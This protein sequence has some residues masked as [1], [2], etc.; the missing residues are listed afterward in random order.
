[1]L[2]EGA[3]KDYHYSLN[4]SYQRYTN[5]KNMIYLP[6]PLNANICPSK[7]ITKKSLITKC[8]YFCFYKKLFFFLTPSVL[9]FFFCASIPFSLNLNDKFPQHFNIPYEQYTYVYYLY[10]M[11]LEL[12]FSLY[13][14]YRTYTL[15]I[16]Y[17]QNSDHPI[18]INLWLVGGRWHD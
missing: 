17:V 13:H 5:T 3:L 9:T 1:M 11:W 6:I 8:Y 7:G 10:F 16:T 2:V 18:F 12:G 14:I 4:V 15:C